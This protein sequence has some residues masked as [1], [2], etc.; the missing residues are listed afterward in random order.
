MSGS[1]SSPSIAD[2]DYQALESALAQSAR[3]RWFLAEYARRNRTADTG[4]LL[5]AVSRLEA[6]VTRERPS[7]AVHRIRFDLVEMAEAIAR[8]KADVAA[9]RAT[10]HLDSASPLGSATETL[11]TIVH[12]TEQATSEILDAAE[13]VQEAAWT[14]REGGADQRLCDDLDRRATAI[15]TACSFQDLT[16]QRSRKVIQ[17]LRY[18]EARINGLIEIWGDKETEADRAPGTGEGVQAGPDLSQ[19]DVDVIVADEGQHPPTV[20]ATSTK[21]ADA[22]ASAP[23]PGLGAVANAEDASTLEG[24][25][26]DAF[27]SIDALDAREK[28]RLFT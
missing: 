26:L 20:A 10:D 15:Y 8:T 17:T 13:Y 12:T 25:D 3:G 23:P 9:L 21:L 27:A 28:L 5:E 18:L 19:S 22:A 2:A 4:A 16:A 6:A 1:R 11:D 14:L 24:L 7:A